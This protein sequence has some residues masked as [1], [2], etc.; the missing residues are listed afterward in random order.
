MKKEY[1]I[2]KKK[3][4]GRTIANIAFK[5]L[6]GI[7]VIIFAYILY[8]K[9][10]YST[11]KMSYSSTKSTPSASVPSQLKWFDDFKG[12]ENVPDKNAKKKKESNGS[13]G[14]NY[15]GFNK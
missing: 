2:Q 4:L 11:G 14:F 9:V 7:A 13:T 12:I 5:V 3:T 8:D 10:D 15:Q 6:V 1:G